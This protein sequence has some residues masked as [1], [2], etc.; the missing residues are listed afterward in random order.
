MLH[1][2]KVKKLIFR[3]GM[4]SKGYVQLLGLESE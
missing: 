3:H 2:M 1:V 4:L